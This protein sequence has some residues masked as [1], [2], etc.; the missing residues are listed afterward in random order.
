M[1]AD[2]FHR[3]VKKSMERNHYVYHFLDFDDAVQAAN[4][5]KVKVVNM[6]FSDCSQR[7]DHSSKYKLKNMKPRVYLF[8]IVLLK[9]HRGNMT[10]EFS[11]YFDAPLR[12]LN[13]IN[14]KVKNGIPKPLSY[15]QPRGIYEEKKKY[16]VSKLCPLMPENCR[17]YWKE[18]PTG[19]G[20]IDLITAQEDHK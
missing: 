3:Q 11:T 19:Y 18:L 9:A 8:D 2:S 20:V 14:S 16:I 10:L 12:K 15:V 17:W 4:S 7:Q 1:S 6:D 5:G 13:F